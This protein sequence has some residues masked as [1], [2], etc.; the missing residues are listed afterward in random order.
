MSPSWR[1]ASRFCSTMAALPFLLSHCFLIIQPPADPG[2]AGGLVRTGQSC[3]HLA[4]TSHAGG[5][6]GA[7]HGLPGGQAAVP[8]LRRSWP[9]QPGQRPLPAGPSS[10]AEGGDHRTLHSQSRCPRR[11]DGGWAHSWALCVGQCSWPTL[12]GLQRGP[13]LVGGLHGAAGWAAP[14]EVTWG[15]PGCPLECLAV[16]PQCPELSAT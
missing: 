14:R 7:S 11:V 16:P 1:C 2:A 8:G 9:R 4:G 10:P 5:G 12:C 15:V 3:P 6:A 13:G